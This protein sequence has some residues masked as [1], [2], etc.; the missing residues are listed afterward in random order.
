[1]PAINQ[2]DPLSMNFGGIVMKSMLSKCSNGFIRLSLMLLFTALLTAFTACGDSDDEINPNY[3]EIQ[4]IQYHY[5]DRSVPPEYHRSY[6]ITIYKNLVN[7]VVDSYGDIL[8]EENYE[9]LSEQF[10]DIISSMKNNEIRNCGLGEDT[11]CSGGDSE[12]VSYVNIKG[13]AFYGEVYHCGGNDYGNLC[14]DV[15]SF[16]DDLESLIPDLDELLQ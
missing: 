15:T 3:D 12:S 13:I 14:G 16:S 8:A 11:G 6:T 9:I 5:G 1:M 4:E 10:E 7:I 2:F